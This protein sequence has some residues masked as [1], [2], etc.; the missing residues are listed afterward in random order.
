[1]NQLLTTLQ[2][3]D[4]PVRLF[5]L[6]E[7]E[8]E[9]VTKED[10]INLLNLSSSTGSCELM[11][12]FTEDA[13]NLI[14]A[15]GVNNVYSIPD[16]PRIVLRVSR[17]P[18]EISSLKVIKEMIYLPK[19]EVNFEEEKEER[20]IL[21]DQIY[22][23]VVGSL[24]S[25][26][27]PDHP[28]FNTLT[29]SFYCENSGKLFSIMSKNDLTLQQFIFAN[30]HLISPE[31]LM[32][33]IFQYL[34]ICYQLTK[35]GIT[36]FDRHLG[37]LMVNYTHSNFLRG[38]RNT[39]GE[40]IHPIPDIRA[41]NNNFIRY[42]SERGV[43]IKIPNYG[44]ILKTI[45]FGISIIERKR[46]IEGITEKYSIF[47]REKEYNVYIP[48]YTCNPTHPTQIPEFI[49]ENIKAKYAIE[50]RG[51]RENVMWYF[52]FKNLEITLEKLGDYSRHLLPTL[53]E[54]KDLYSQDCGGGRRSFAID[55]EFVWPGW[56]WLYR[57]I[58]VKDEKIRSVIEKYINFLI[59]KGLLRVK[60]DGSLGF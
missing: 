55:L 20:Y 6:F 42:T 34:M 30:Y 19:D 33:I 2:E 43:E 14:G 44:I 37:N 23:I 52:F 10:I 60:E 56:Y 7:S 54:I 48:G 31:L 22:D 27:I 53:K 12:G 18:L 46:N 51:I 57:N 32:N 13:S 35:I 36:D 1:M 24:I 41:D 8:G 50:N 4:F 29:G 47:N 40:E 15:G 28:N 16:Q 38:V 26:K 59:G 39:N 9:G 49:N 5:N 25:S 21:S 58:G 45:D 3:L 11:E 17:S